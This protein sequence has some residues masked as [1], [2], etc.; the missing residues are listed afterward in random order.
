MNYLKPHRRFLRACFSTVLIAALLLTGTSSNKPVD[1]Q[2]VQ[3][4]AMSITAA[5]AI[6]PTALNNLG[7]VAGVWPVSLGGTG[8]TTSTGTGA[9][10]L[11]TNPVLLTGFQLNT[12][13]AQGNL[14]FLLAGTFSQVL[15]ANSGA[16]SMGLLGGGTGDNS[17]YYDAPTGGSHIFRIQQALAASISANSINIPT[18]SVYAVNN[19]QITA[20]NLAI[21]GTLAGTTIDTTNIN[22]RYL[23]NTSGIAVTTSTTLQTV[24]F[25]QFVLTSSK[26]YVC[27]GYIHFT[28]APTGSNGLKIAL[29]SSGG[30]TAT[31]MIFTAWAQ[32]GFTTAPVAG[33]SVSSFTANVAQA[34]GSTVA[35]TD[36]FM[37]AIISTNVGGNLDLQIAENASSGTI[38][39]TANNVYWHCDRT[40]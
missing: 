33:G 25:V 18:G 38:A 28:T 15:F 29:V 17:L 35:M 19:S 10:V 12:G 8:V 2:M 1:A 40:N 5:N 7:A 16:S 22:Q 6:L 3:G 11:S 27:E 26:R 14:K 21:G 31:D 30:L 34:F 24:S 13:A 20:S 39:A 23:V 4:G 36:V 37:K 32:N 9:V